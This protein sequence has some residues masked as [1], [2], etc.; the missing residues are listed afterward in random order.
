MG[1]RETAERAEALGGVAVAAHPYRFWSG[2]G[3]PE[4]LRGKFP[5]FEVQ[6]AR[7]LHG[8]NR[9]ARNLA[10]LHERG[11]TGGSD[12][13]FLDEVGRA[14]TVFED[15]HTEDGLLNQLGKGKTQAA[16]ADRDARGILRYVPKA[17]GEWAVRGFRR[18]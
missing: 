8:G 9:R 2:L 7:T 15:A 12:A 6:N 11:A 3:E 10:T 17:I 16:G 5:A 13:H 18:I 1:T 14:W 4:T